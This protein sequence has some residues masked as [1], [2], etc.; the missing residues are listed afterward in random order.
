MPL[1]VVPFSREHADGAAALLAAR[2]RADRA[3]EPRLPARF[4]RV[5]EARALIE[6]TARSQATSGAVAMWQER[7]VG[8]L[9]G[10]LVLP[11][12]SSRGA[13]FLDPRSAFVSY[14]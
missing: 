12:P 9:F 3:R 11:A 6:A 4:E 1:V 5:E 7:I 13:L 14:G 2:H 10:S 8:F